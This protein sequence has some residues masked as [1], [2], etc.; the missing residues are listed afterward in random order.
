MRTPA[1]LVPLL[2]LAALALSGC[3]AAADKDLSWDD[4]PLS[5][6]L[7]SA[8]GGDL[9]PEEQQQRSDEMQK[10][11]EDSV[12][13]CMSAEGFEYIPANNSGSTMVSSGE[14]WKP[15]DRE[16]VSQ[17]GYGAIN[18][19][20]RDTQTAAPS[21]E[22]YVD[23]NQ[24]YVESLS[25]SERTAY[26]ET[27]WGAASTQ[28][29]AEGETYEY[30]WEEHGCQGKAQQEVNAAQNVWSR[31]EFK[32]LTEAMNQLYATTSTS[33]EQQKLDGEWASCMA[34]AGHAGFSVQTDAANSIYEKLNALSQDMPQPDPTLSESEIMA[35][36]AQQEKERQEKQAPMQD[37]EIA[38]ALAD[39]D[40]R[41][42]TD[43][44]PTQL[45]LQFAAEEQF[46]KDHKTELEAFKAAAEQQQR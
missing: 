39:L 28:E 19:P 15:D 38:L 26:Q 21:T 31:D 5:A 7:S 27:L 41:E 3:G 29:P 45:K 16:F 42:K 14:E 36:Y 9:S 1:R 2:A 13:A 10:K 40:C 18:Y 24:S 33:P 6:Y 37:E 23:P 8:F 4:S 11:I 22:Q 44:R 46:I 35:F 34:D 20:G 25:E 17:Y 12:A 32:E 30:K 43:Y